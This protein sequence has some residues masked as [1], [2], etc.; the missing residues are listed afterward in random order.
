MPADGERDT[1]PASVAQSSKNMALTANRGAAGPRRIGRRLFIAAAAT[2]AVPAA[3]TRRTPRVVFLNPGSPAPQASGPMSR[4]AV[5]FMVIAAAQLGV[6]LE[7]LHA[8]HDHLLMI[9]HARAVAARAEAPDYV[10]LV[11]DKMAAP[12]MFEALA[13][14]SPRLFVIHSD[15]TTEQ[16]RDTG[17]ERERYPRW[18][19]S[20][21]PDNTRGVYRLVRALHQALGEQPLRAI[22]IT[23]PPSTPVSNERAQGLTDAIASIPGARL[24]QLVFSDWSEADAHRKAWVLLARYPDTNLIWA[25]N[26]EM[27]MG[28][29]RAAGERGMSVVAGG[30]GGWSRALRSVADGGMTATLTG[31]HLIGALALVM[32][33]DHANG[34]DFAADGGVRRKLDYLHIVTR[35]NL[36]EYETTFGEHERPINFRRYSK[37]HQP[38]LTHYDFSLA[39]LLARSN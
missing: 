25:A 32:L 31:H 21:S 18:I 14:S 3:A 12:A 9:R 38:Q 36:R 1:L 35:A 22:G 15:V 13:A 17:N 2:V 16:R 34:I 27:A 8:Q 33:H 20:A 37:V 30:M 7:V 10:V 6:E 5:D 29:L 28:A 26:D 39:P 11:N 24:E 4:A 19:G 23:G